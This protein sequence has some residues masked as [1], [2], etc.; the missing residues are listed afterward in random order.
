M[1]SLDLRLRVDV[2]G[3]AV[4]GARTATA[5]RSAVF[6]GTTGGIGTGSDLNFGFGSRWTSGAAVADAVCRPRWSSLAFKL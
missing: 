6:A 5:A 2:G 3:T 4:A 1:L